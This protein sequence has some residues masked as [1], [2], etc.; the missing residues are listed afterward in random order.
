MNKYLFYEGHLNESDISVI[1]PPFEEKC[2][3]A[4]PK[5]A[6][7]SCECMRYL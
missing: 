6:A 7:E 2:D 1:T 3:C 5:E 4:C